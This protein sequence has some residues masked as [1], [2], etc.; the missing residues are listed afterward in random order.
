MNS[1]ESGAGRS[2]ATAISVAVAVPVVGLVIAA[3]GLVPQLTATTTTTDGLSV[4]AHDGI[5][6]ND[7]TWVVP[8]DAPWS[9]FPLFSS[10]DFTIGCSP[11]QLGWLSSNAVL[12]P[13]PIRF[14]F[15]NR[16][17]AGQ[18]LSIHSIHLAGKESDPEPSIRLRCAENGGGQGGVPMVVSGLQ[19]GSEA[20]A[21]VGPDQEDIPGSDVVYTPGEIVTFNLRPGDT[22]QLFLALDAA[23]DLRTF[24]GAVVAT[25]SSGDNVRNVELPLPHGDELVI[26]VETLKGDL[27]E[28]NYGM[29]MCGWADEKGRLISSSGVRCSVTDIVRRLEGDWD[30]NRSGQISLSGN[31]SGD[32]VGDS[33]PYSINV[34]ILED[35]N[36]ASATATYP[37]IP[38][39]A[40]WTLTSRSDSAVTFT[41]RVS[42]EY[43]CYDNVPITIKFNPD[44]SLQYSAL[45]GGAVITATLF[46]V[47]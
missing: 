25:V 16:A 3:V 33:H 46:R 10:E 15:A 41:E 44:G 27:I 42:Q 13:E 40:T 4:T 18:S 24:T 28:V 37:E 12:V 20:P 2:R 6:M 17:D 11:E 34:T 9:D 31:W 5:S 29:A 38:C 22:S 19:A 26:P 7:T 47:G 39:A 23:A 1:V 43:V 36:V 45:S 14:E 35:G 30:S 32:V 21:V 8:V